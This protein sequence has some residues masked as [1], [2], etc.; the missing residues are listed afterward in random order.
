MGQLDS[1]IIL[2]LHNPILKYFSLV[3]IGGGG[4]GYINHTSIE[5]HHTTDFSVNVGYG[6]SSSRCDD[7]GYI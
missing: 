6:G 7:E 1:R 4:S 3:P 2:P 5:I